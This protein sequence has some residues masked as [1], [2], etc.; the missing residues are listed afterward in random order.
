MKTIYADLNNVDEEGCIRL[1]CVQTLDDIET[2][3]IKLKD[4]LK[5]KLK[6]GDLVAEG[7]VMYSKVESIWTVLVEK[8]VS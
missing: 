3:G 7:R 5:I 6:D 2:Q 4:G 8:Y 1:N